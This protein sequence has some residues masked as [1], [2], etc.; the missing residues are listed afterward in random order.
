[1]T[2]EESLNCNPSCLL[3]EFYMSISTYTLSWTFIRVY[4]RQLTL[5]IAPQSPHIHPH[6][7]ALPSIKLWKKYKTGRNNRKEPYVL[8]G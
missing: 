2:A 6:L 5:S 4:L 8:Y 3:G 7:R 1:M